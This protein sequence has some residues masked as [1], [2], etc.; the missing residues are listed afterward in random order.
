[1]LRPDLGYFPSLFP[2]LKAKGYPLLYTLAKTRRIQT[3]AHRNREW[4]RLKGNLETI[5]ANRLFSQRKNPK[6]TEVKPHKHLGADPDLAL[7][8]PSSS[9][10]DLGAIKNHAHFPHTPGHSTFPRNSRETHKQGRWH[11]VLNCHMDRE[12]RE[13]VIKKKKRRHIL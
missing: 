11:N 3:A 6:P 12:A 1:M 9:S 4:E 5:P 10:Y 7:G 8:S 2:I 13:A